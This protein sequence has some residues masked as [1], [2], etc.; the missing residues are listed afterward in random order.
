ME[1]LAFIRMLYQQG[2]ELSRLPEPLSASSVLTL[3]DAS[4]LFLVLAGEHLNASLDKQTQFMAYWKMLSPQKLSPGVTLPSQQQMSRLN[5]LRNALKHHGT[6]PSRAAIDQACADVTLFLEAA[7]ISVFGISFTD[8]DMAEVIPQAKARSKVKAASAA[9]AAGDL[10]DAMG[11]LA[12]TFDLLTAEV[13]AP[14]R[15]RR[16]GRF[17]ET[18]RRTLREQQI[19]QVLTKPDGDKR[20]PA[21]GTM[22]LAGELDQ[23]FSAAQEMQDALRLMVIGIDYRQLDRFRRLTPRIIYFANLHTERRAAPGYAPDAGHFDECRQFIITLAL[24]MAELEAHVRP[25][26][27]EN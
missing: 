23:V 17:G 24:R 11:E 4:E 8:I 12:E 21:G 3:H 26:P 7:T 9:A 1:R 27:W 16:F 5:E 25:V 22:R 15:R 6:L 2:M 10:I 18:I 20:G 19:R 14:G 13:P